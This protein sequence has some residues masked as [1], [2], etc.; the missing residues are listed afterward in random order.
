MTVKGKLEKQRTKDV[1]PR[2][3]REHLGI[4]TSACIAA[5][6]E[7]KTYYNWRNSDPEFAAACDEVQEVAHDFV[8][9]KLHQK[10]NDG[11]TACIIFYCKT[12]MRHRGYIERFDRVESDS[13]KPIQLTE[14]DDEIIARAIARHMEAKH[15]KDSMPAVN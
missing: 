9:S 8:E 13:M 5:Q 6:I 15:A 12:R 3:L 7:R 1:F 10:I 11:D 4:V 14:S 2:I